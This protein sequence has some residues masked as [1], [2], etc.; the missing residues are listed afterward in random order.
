[1]FGFLGYFIVPFFVKVL[2]AV[3]FSRSAVVFFPGAQYTGAALGPLLVS[4]V[5]ASGQY[6]GGLLVDL[7]LTLGAIG[8]LW[9]GL[10]GK[11]RVQSN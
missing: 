8:S 2:A 10:L 5:V 4:F 6:R 9:I 11:R 7:T 1:L 3:D